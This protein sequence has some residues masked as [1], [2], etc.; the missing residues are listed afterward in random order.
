MDSEQLVTAVQIAE[1]IP[2]VSRHLVYVWRG[3]GKLQPQ[4]RR[5]RSPVYR[6]S[7]VVAVEEATRAADPAAQR[8]RQFAA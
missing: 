4:G 8:A 7:D 1:K 5:G 6:W 3:Q 2:S